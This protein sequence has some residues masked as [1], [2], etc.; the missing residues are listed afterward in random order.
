MHGGVEFHGGGVEASGVDG[1][2]DPAALG[3]VV[4]E[5][6]SLEEEL[7]LGWGVEGGGG[8]GE[9]WGGTGEGGEGGW[10]VKQDPLAGFCGDGHL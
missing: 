9:G 4:G 10:F 8:E 7:V 3:G 2:G 6:E 5:V 1:G